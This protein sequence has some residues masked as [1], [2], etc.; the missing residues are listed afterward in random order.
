MKNYN[1]SI[2]KLTFSH[3]RSMTL[4]HY[5]LPHPWKTKALRKYSL[6]LPDVQLNVISAASTF[7]CRDFCNFRGGRNLLTFNGIPK[8]IIHIPLVSVAKK[9][10]IDF[11]YLSQNT[12]RLFYILAL[13]F[14]SEIWKHKRVFR[15]CVTFSWR[16]AAIIN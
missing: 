13:V 6:L 15:L 1:S 8:I 7:L 10:T 12:N 4:C 2:R 3:S 9:L 14:G 16:I 5:L 11:M